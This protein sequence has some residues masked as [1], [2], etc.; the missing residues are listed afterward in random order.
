MRRSCNSCATGTSG[1]ADPLV[2]VSRGPY[3]ELTGPP[4]SHDTFNI[5]PQR[6]EPHSTF[7]DP[8]SGCSPIIGFP[9]NFEL[10][11]CGSENTHEHGS[12]GSDTKKL[13]DDGAHQH[14]HNRNQS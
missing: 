13:D 9:Q 10:R 11:F 7:T 12:V 5:F 8:T 2:G 4:K 14:H 6:N 1:E 3:T